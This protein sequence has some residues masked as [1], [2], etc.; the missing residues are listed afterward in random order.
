MRILGM[1][2]SLALVLLLSIPAASALAQPCVLEDN[3]SGTVD[4]PPEGCGYLSPADVHEF[5]DNSNL[6]PGTTIEFD[7]SHKNFVCSHGGPGGPTGY[8]GS[9]SAVID[10]ETCE[11]PGPAVGQVVEC[12][13]SDA[14]IS[15]QGT[16]ALAGYTEELTIPLFTEVLSNRG[17]N[18][19]NPS[20]GTEMTY[21]GGSLPPGA[22]ANFCNLR[23]LG[24][25]DNTGNSN[26][27]EVNLTPVPGCKFQL[28]SFFDVSYFMHY[29]GCPGG[30]LDGLNGVSDVQTVHVEAEA[31]PTAVPFGSPVT[32]VLLIVGAIAGSRLVGRRA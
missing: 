21:L 19:P 29:S 23:I 26:P 5:I 32:I 25:T 10:P 1:L 20:F 4:L 9:C 18:D 11:G 15:L 6:P 31:L 24:G 13:S 8:G 16:G 17:L 2:R 3:G 7:I 27:G 28:D 14:V 30:V 12:F 22:S